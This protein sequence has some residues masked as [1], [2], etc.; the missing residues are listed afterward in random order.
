MKAAGLGIWDY[1]F[2]ADR[3]VCSEQTRKLLGVDTTEALS[4]GQVLS[5][6]HPEDRSRVAKHIA[7]SLHSDSDYVDHVEFR[8]VTA[9]G[10]IRWLEN[11]G[12]VEIRSAGEPARAFGVL[13]DI[14][15]RKDAEEAQER[16]AS[17]VKSSADAIISKTLDGIITTWN[18]AAERI[19]GYSPAEMI[20]QSVRRLIPADRQQEEDMV[21]ASV[22]R[23]ERIEN[24]ETL[25]VA[26]NGRPIDVS[27]T[28]SPVQNGAGRII[29]A[30]T[31]A[32]DITDRKRAEERLQRQADLLNQSHDAILAWR[33]GDGI[34][35]WSKGAERLYGYTA[36]EAAGQSSHELL[37]TCS[38]I[39]VQEIEERIVREGSWYGE[40]LHTTRDGRAIVVESRHVRIS[41]N[42]ELHA[43][44]TNRDITQ[45]KASEEQIQ[46]LM[47]E[48]NHRAKNM[49]SVVHAIAHQT[50]V[51]S[52]GDFMERFSERI[53]ALSASQDLLVRNEWNGVEIEELVKTQL[54]LFAGLVGSRIAL[55]GPKLRLSPAAAQAIGL[56]VHELATNAGKYGALSSVRG[57]I[58]ISWGT[59]GDAFTM[60]WTER[61][62]PHVS[63]PE[64]R[65]FGTIVTK[66]MVER[67]LDGEV[68]IEFAPAGLTWRLTCPAATVLEIWMLPRPSGSR[69]KRVSATEK[70]RQVL[71]RLNQVNAQIRSADQHLGRQRE[72]LARLERDGRDAS[73]AK[74]L[75]Y[76]FEEV[77]ALHL[78]TRNRL[79]KELAGL[80]LAQ[81]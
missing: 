81:P 27:V 75:L 18:E 1:D 32:R 60:S 72:I 55:Q 77:Q 62:G 35:Y 33:L 46:F 51:R 12:W 47:R 8:V 76:Q 15:G 24:H 59:R 49:L 4:L 11:Q 79:E 65:G 20:G 42:G 21:L 37:R 23:G 10:K 52:P 41:Y 36:E 34:S 9:D 16:L 56:A 54:A 58:D 5:R 13:R 31:I 74:R 53:Q 45:R 73:D 78:A 61:D 6:A 48:V 25:R 38:P 19:L 26:K 17:I 28:V 39:P 66:A 67:S 3:I 70:M 50:A 44:E 40:L 64:R 69:E 71:E 22:A 43:L 7:R 29:G 80:T 68:D 57:R 14:T 2:A 30:S 63:E